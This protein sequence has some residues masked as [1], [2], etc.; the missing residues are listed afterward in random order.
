MLLKYTP[1]FAELCIA[2]REW[3]GL[4]CYLL[5]LP[6]ELRMHIFSY[7]LP[8]KPINCWLDAPLRYDRERC[9]WE[10]LFVNRQ[11][12]AEALDILYGSQPFTLSL[13]RDNL[14]LCGGIYS[15]DR[16]EWPSIMIFNPPR[17]DRNGH[18]PPMLDKIKNLRLQVSFVNPGFPAGRPQHFP[19]WEESIDLYD[20]RDSAHS[21]VHLLQESGTVLQS[22]SIVLIAQNTVKSWSSDALYKILKTII[23]P[24][25]RLRHIPKV[26]L[27][28]VCQLHFPHRLSYTQYFLDNIK[29]AP[30]DCIVTE[31]GEPVLEYQYSGQKHKTYIKVT[32]PLPQHAEFQK[33]KIDWEQTIKSS[34]PVPEP[35]QQAL[36]AFESFRKAYHAVEGQFRT[37]LPR[38]KNWLLHRARVCREQN[39]IEGITNLR[40]ELEAEVARLVEAERA[41]ITLREK[42][43]IDALKA[44]DEE[45]Q[46][47]SRKWKWEGESEGYDEDPLEE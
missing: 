38:G 34:T 5:K 43:A 18:P 30:P 40:G 8:D 9:T 4:P 31:A 24:F 25:E 22:L 19:T 27:E 32:K 41:T 42:T 13:G 2:H 20:L 26:M 35:P 33:L 12:S 45:R 17:A 7:L 11:I 37:V 29:P 21:F 1:S 36:E 10:L 23:E 3:N 44:F 14:V 39:D 46:G 15:Y 28:G 47:A 16:S 6:V